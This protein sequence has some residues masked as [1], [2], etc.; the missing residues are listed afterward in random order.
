MSVRAETPNSLPLGSA[1]GL[2]AAAVVLAM[3]IMLAG[4]LAIYGL[5]GALLFVLFVGYP[6]LGLYATTALLLLSG[7]SG[8]IGFVNEDATMAVTLSKLSGSAALAAWVANILLRKRPLEVNW[9]VV[10]LGAFVLWSLLG[11][12]LSVDVGQTWAHWV[13]LLTLLGYFLLAVNTLNTP[14]NLHLFVIIVVVCGIITAVAAV[15]QYFLPQYQVAGAEAWARLGAV[16]AAFI[17]QES[18]QGEAAIRVSGRAGHS[19]WLAMIILLVMPLNLYWFSTTPSRRLKAFLVLGIGVELMALV[20]T[21]TRTGFVIGIIMAALLLLKRFVRLTALRFFAFLL[22]LVVVWVLLPDAYKERVF[23]PTQYTGSKSVQSRLQLQESAARYLI[24]NPVA[25]LGAGGFGV[26]FV[27]ENNETAQTMGFM[28]DRMGW[29]PVFVGAHN[30]FLEIGAD[31]GGVGLLLYLAFFVLMLRGVFLEEQRCRR[32]GDTNGAALAG[33][34]FVSLVG[35]LLC[36]VFLHALH[37]KIWWMMA[38][39][40]VAMPLYHLRF[41]DG[42]GPLL[43]WSSEARPK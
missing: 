38:A 9:P 26:S 13:R 19:N 16:D 30:M 8:I 3:A 23:S 24:E 5:I 43:P 36:A 21:Y 17:D 33:A 39:A 42:V 40:A 18:L 2:L 31:A 14:K 12:I 20:L 35:F 27:N 22:S 41:K 6:V 28:V 11:S 37:Q 25:G 10:L 4:K 7:S 1:V 32:E 15:A 34:L 29:L